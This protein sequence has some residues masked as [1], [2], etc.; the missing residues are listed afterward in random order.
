MNI[1]RIAPPSFRPHRSYTEV[2]QA[3]TSVPGEW[4]RIPYSEVR[5]ETSAA[6]QSSIHQAATVR[7]LQVETTIRGEFLYVRLKG[8]V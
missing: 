8:A 7:G 1:E 5:G 2:I 4:V 6:R 3:I